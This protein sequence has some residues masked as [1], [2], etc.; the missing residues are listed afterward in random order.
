MKNS[1]DAESTAALSQSAV[2]ESTASTSAASKSNFS[3]RSLLSFLLVGGFATAVQYSITAFLTL[4]LNV[5]V[6]A[7]SAIGFCISSVAN[8][9]LNAKMTFKSQQS[10]RETFPRFCVTAGAGLTINTLVLSLLITN[11]L[12]PAVSQLLTTVCVILWNYSI[13]GIWTFRKA[14][15]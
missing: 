9:L 15:T 3:F 5:P 12:H 2:C 6:V 7:A 4:V 11:G 10:H 8:Y 13:N 14:K 1:P